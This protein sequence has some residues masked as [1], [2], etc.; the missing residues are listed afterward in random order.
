ML[1]H[2]TPP[3]QSP[4]IQPTSNITTAKAKVSILRAKA[5]DAS[6]LV[7]IAEIV[8]REIEKERSTS[9]DGAGGAYQ[10]SKPGRWFQY[11]TL[12]EEMQ[13]RRREVGNSVIE[14]TVLGGPGVN[15]EG[16]DDGDEFEIMKTP[17]ER[18]VQGQPLVRGVPVM[19]L[20]L[21]RSS[22]DELKRQ[23]GEQTNA[24]RS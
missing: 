8:K 3:P 10:G 11:I 22:I 5:S 7:S 9:N 17:F 13:W 14:D 18:A 20:F 2:L 4:S 6:K 16:L 21:S 24:P 19:S 23:Y 15:E 1:R 12:G